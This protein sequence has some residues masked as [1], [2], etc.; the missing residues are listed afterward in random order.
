VALS[1]ASHADLDAS[2]TMR[3]QAAAASVEP[4]ECRIC[5]DSAESLGGLVDRLV[6]SLAASCGDLSDMTASMYRTWLRTVFTLLVLD[7]V[8]YKKKMAVLRIG[9]AGGLRAVWTWHRLFDSCLFSCSLNIAP[10]A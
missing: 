8:V 7:V 3:I 4:L 10:H 2:S 6:S 5:K 9:V 1:G